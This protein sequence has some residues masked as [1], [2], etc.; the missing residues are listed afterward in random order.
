MSINLTNMLRAVARQAAQAARL[1]ATTCR[2]YATEAG[3][4]GGVSGNRPAA[5]KNPSD[6]TPR[7]SCLFRLWI[8]AKRG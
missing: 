5:G 7:L 8:A 3:K 6:W 1:G 2:G 4:Q